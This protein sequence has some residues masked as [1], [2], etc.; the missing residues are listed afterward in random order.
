MITMPGEIKSV[1]E[2]AQIHHETIK[3]ANASFAT[4]GDAPASCFQLNSPTD[5]MRAAFGSTN[6][7]CTNLSGYLER[8]VERILLMA[9][10]FELWD[11]QA[12]K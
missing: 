5:S 10:E 11:Q 12:G 8:D 2:I 4:V 1:T 9:E 3:T 7:I 6:T